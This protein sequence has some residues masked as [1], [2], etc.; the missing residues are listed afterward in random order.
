MRRTL[1]LGGTAWLGGELA[2]Q[3]AARGDEVACLARGET[4]QVPDGVRLIRANRDAPDAYADVADSDWDVVV[5]VSRQPGQVRSAV[6]ALADRAR[7]WVFVSSCSVYADHSVVGADESAALLPALTGDHADVETYGEGKVACEEICVAGLGDRVTLARSGLIGGWGDGS[8]R[9]GYWPGRFALAADQPVLVPDADDMASQIIH[10]G[11]LAAWLLLAGE[12]RLGGAYN[13]LGP[14]ERLGDTL[15]LARDVGGHTGDVVRVPSSWLEE[16][17]VG[18]YMGERSVPLWIPD[19][20]WVG[21]SERTAAKAVAAGLVRRPTEETM[22]DAL[23]YERELGLDR[24]QRRAGLTPQQER[25]LL[26]AW[27]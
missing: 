19:P 7:H 1:I 15:R 13:V 22:R 6:E 24:T 3:A 18:P 10:V 23:A 27:A 11:D 8:D 2:R 12:E 5:D 21:F 20:D 14:T 25:E 4:G 26:A 17:G 16:Q 9:F